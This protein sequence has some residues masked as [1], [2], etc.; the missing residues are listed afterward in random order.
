[1]DAE[2][3]WWLVVLLLVGGGSIAYLALGPVPEIGDEPAR[4]A[5]ELPA[6]EGR[7]A[8]PAAPPTRQSP[9]VRTTLPGAEEPASASDTP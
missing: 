7:G 3:L 6:A 5:D 1:M 9:P 8:A 4:D 2:Y